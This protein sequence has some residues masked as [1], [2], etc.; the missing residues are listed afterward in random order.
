MKKFDVIIIGGGPAGT[1]TGLFLRNRGYHILLLDQARFPRDK[2][3]GEFISPAADFILE[4]L[5]ALSL[6]E[7]ANPLRLEGVCI[8]SYENNELSVT[9]PPKPGHPRRMTSLSLPRIVLDNILLNRARAEGIE[10]REGYRVDDFIFEN[11][12]VAGV[13]GRDAEQTRFAFRAPVVVDAGGRNCISIRRLGLNKPARGPVRIA[14]AAHWQNV[15]LPRKLCYMHISPPGYTGMAPVEEDQV[16]VVLVV[17]R[18]DLR[19]EDI[20]D[21]YMRT[22]LKNQKR[23]ALLD[24]GELAEQPRTVESLAFRV[25][26]VPCGGLV[27]A[28]DA[29]G[30]IDPFTGE[31]IYLSLRSAQMAAEVIGTGLETVD[32]SRNHLSACERMRERE[33]NKKFRL[34]RILQRLI[35]N[36]SL[37]NRVVDTLAQNPALAKTLIG[38]IGDYIP[39]KK[40]VSLDYLFKLLGAMVSAKRNGVDASVNK[41]KIQTSHCD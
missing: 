38:V 34:S 7:A 35:Y 30:F 15:R 32:S 36:P 11:G 40:V 25:K 4:E 17:E 14:L 26:R 2:V 13:R 3:C 20:R 33:F 22:V 24:G 31:G 37:C 16:N 8:S 10:V 5:G 27:L 19:G 28:G 39:A 12:D 6:I 23:R 29:T 18:N 1:A 9:F 41:V 21:F